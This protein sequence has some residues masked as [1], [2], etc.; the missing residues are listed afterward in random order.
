MAKAAGEV[1]RPRC[2]PLES[3]SATSPLLY[4]DLFGRSGIRLLFESIYSDRKPR[5]GQ[6]SSASFESA[7]AVQALG[8]SECEIGTSISLSS[9]F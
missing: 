4:H 6:I 8:D 1:Q 2:S 7:R 3:S 9:I 5:D